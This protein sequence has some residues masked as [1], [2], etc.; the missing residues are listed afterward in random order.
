MKERKYAGIGSRQTPYL[1]KATFMAIAKVLAAEGY[2]LRSGGA[3]GA[4]AA[5]ESG[6]RLATKNPNATEIYL[7]WR[8]FNEN[9]SPLYHVCEKA[10]EM[11]AQ[12]HPHWRHLGPVVQKLHARN[13][14][15]ILGQNL[16]DPVDFVICWT[17][18]GEGGGGTG[19][20]LRIASKYRIPIMDFGKI[21]NH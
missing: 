20:A 10:L 3:Y 15:Q 19:Q 6:A 1:V 5:F 4:D 7:P 17:R 9:K 12:F 11:A 16:N 13:C 18:N 14:Y 2:I 21:F 8:G